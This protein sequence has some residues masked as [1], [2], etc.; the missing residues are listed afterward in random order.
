MKET[1]RGLT[2]IYKSN[3]I[4]FPAGLDMG[5][6]KFRTFPRFLT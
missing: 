5:L 6:G 4:G 1:Q 3:Y 2:N